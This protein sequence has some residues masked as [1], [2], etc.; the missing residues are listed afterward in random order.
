MTAA[1]SLQHALNLHAQGRFAEAEQGYLRCL[2]DHPDSGDAMGMLGM[3][4]LQTG[5]LREALPH[6]EKAVVRCPKQA[7]YHIALGEAWRLLGQPGEALASYETAGRL[8]PNNADLHNSTGIVLRDLDR[9]EEAVAHLERALVLDPGFAEARANLGKVYLELGRHAAALACFDRVP[10][11][12]RQGAEYLGLMGKA[13]AGLGNRQEAIDHYRRALA[14]NPELAEVRCALGNLYLEQNQDEEAL[15]QYRIAQRQLPD[16]AELLCNIGLAQKKLGRADDAEAQYRRALAGDPAHVLTLNNYGTLLQEQGRLAEAR[17]C[18]EKALEAQPDNPLILYGLGNLCLEEGRLAEAATLLERTLALR[19]DYPEARFCQGLVRFMEG[20]LAGGWAGYE[21]RWHGSNIGF[22]R[23]EIGLPHWRGEP[24]AAGAGLLVYSEQGYGDSLQFIRYLP[25]VAARFARVVLYTHRPLLDLFRGL[26][27]ANCE[28][29]ELAGDIEAAGCQWQVP[30]L[31]LPLALATTL[32]TVPDRVPYLAADPERAEHWRRWLAE[33]DDGRMRVGL[34][35]AG[36]PTLKS[37]RKRSVPLAAFQPLL[38]RPGI[39]WVS[40]QKGDAA[41][42]RQQLP[43]PGRLLDPMQEVGD[44]A[45]TAALLMNLDLIVSVDTA[46]VHLAGALARPVWL[47]NRHE[48]E[49]RWMRGRDTSPWYPT[50]RIFNQPRPGEWGGL[51]ARV[52]EALDG[53]L[54]ARGARP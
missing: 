45:D 49:W 39:R 46:V 17:P 19:P 8:L 21:Y 20:D 29:R 37:D 53:E 33:R 38:N 14:E 15:K 41:Q 50:M 18:F 6:L 22:A 5:R 4:R 25:L 40:L 34:V 26:C 2:M 23:P 27:P 54:A 32:E 28:I 1:Q 42:Q 24:P 16:S 51:L 48:S 13:Q 11:A 52:G 44:F 7:N 43:D 36:R 31:S 9:K 12:Q 10:E 3:L 35:W 30:L 47:L